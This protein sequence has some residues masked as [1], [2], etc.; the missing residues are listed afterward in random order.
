MANFAECTLIKLVPSEPYFVALTTFDIF[1]GRSTR[2]LIRQKDLETLVNDEN[3][4]PVLDTDIG[5][6]IQISRCNMHLCFKLTLLHQDYRNDVTGY[7]HCFELPVKKVESVLYG[8]SIHHVEYASGEKSKAQLM[9]TESGHHA[10]G[11]YCQDKLTRH[12]LR[13]F[14]RDH[15]N[16]GQDEQIMIYPDNWVKGFYFQCDRL[17]GGIVRHEDTVTGKNGREYRKV[18]Y[19]IHT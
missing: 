13:R 10:L 6:Y 14:F 1:H 7:I 2:F 4:A 3:A 11:K 17:N 18:F 5:S 8:E 16:Y 12:A 15:F 9:I 19:A